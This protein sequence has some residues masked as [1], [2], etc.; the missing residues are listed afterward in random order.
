MG[1]DKNCVITSQMFNTVVKDKI[2]IFMSFLV[3]AAK[4]NKQYI[5]VYLLVLFGNKEWNGGNE[6]ESFILYL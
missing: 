5:K 6:N 2:S 1:G 4:Y 3:D